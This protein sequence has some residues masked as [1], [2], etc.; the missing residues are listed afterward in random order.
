MGYFSSHPQLSPFAV[1][2]YVDKLFAEGWGAW[3]VWCVAWLIKIHPLE[4][5]GE[6]QDAIA[7]RPAPEGFGGSQ[8]MCT[9]QNPVGA[10]LP[11][12]LFILELA[13]P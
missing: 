3:R 4:V 1:G 8:L 10:G 12:M 9:P 5:K 6:C 13:H 7:G 2:G 11:V